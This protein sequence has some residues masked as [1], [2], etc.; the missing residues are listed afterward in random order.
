MRKILVT[1]DN[2][3][4]REI[5]KDI[6]CDDYEVLEAENGQEAL[7][8]LNEQYQDISVM[9]LDLHMPVMDGFALLKILHTDPLLSTVPVIVMTAD[10]NADTEERCMDLGAVEF[11]EKPYNRDGAG[12]GPQHGAHARGG[13]GD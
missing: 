7:A 12:K 10:E 11:L 9:L 2:L 6:L 5:L 4:N 1:E 3:M 8:I 13:Q